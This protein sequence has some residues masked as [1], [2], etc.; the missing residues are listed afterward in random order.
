VWAAVWLFLFVGTLAAAFLHPGKIPWG[1]AHSA[2]FPSAVV[3]AAL[4]WGLLSRA[5][6]TTAAFVSG[7]MVLEFLLMFWSHWW[8]LFHDPEVLEPGSGV[9]GPREP[10][11]QMLNESLGSGDLLFLA[12]A[13][14]IQV[15]LIVLLFRL[16]LSPR[17]SQ[18]AGEGL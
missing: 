17:E 16:V 12:A 6:P 14:I 2:A 15:V 4:A 9:I 8:L 7:G 3:L 5:G 18:P 10:D 11:V 1:I 13:V